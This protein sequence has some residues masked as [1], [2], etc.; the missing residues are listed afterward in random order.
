MIT[1]LLKLPSSLKSMLYNLQEIFFVEYAYVL[2]TFIS[3]RNSYVAF[4]RN[5]TFWE[6]NFDHPNF[7]RLK[8]KDILLGHSLQEMIKHK[9]CGK[10]VVYVDGYW[11]DTFSDHNWYLMLSSD[12]SPINLNL[13]DC[14]RAQLWW[15]GLIETFQ[16][17]LELSGLEYYYPLQ[18]E[19][20]S[21]WVNGRIMLMIH[22]CSV[23]DIPVKVE[24]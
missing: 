20:F 22:I 4:T 6:A 21:E 17:T 11:T 13:I 1:F 12:A 5:S 8:H 9:L 2:T 14:G 10:L 19:W 16:G 7:V 18:T 24:V 23:P 3:I 15:P